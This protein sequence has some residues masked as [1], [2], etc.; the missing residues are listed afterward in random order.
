VVIIGW[1]VVIGSNWRCL[2]VIGWRVVV[3]SN[4]VRVVAVVLVG[5]CHVV[6]SLNCKNIPQSLMHPHTKNGFRGNL[7]SPR[8]S[9]IWGGYD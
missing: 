1:H 7:G 5:Q 9:H 8:H 6:V 3:G 2:V 4:W